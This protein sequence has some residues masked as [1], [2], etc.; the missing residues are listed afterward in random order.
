[1]YSG[2]AWALHERGSF[3]ITRSV[4]QLFGRAMQR[5]C[6]F[7]MVFTNNGANE[8]IVLVTLS[9]FLVSAT[10]KVCLCF[11]FLPNLKIEAI[12]SM[13]S[14]SLLLALWWNGAYLKTGILE[15]CKPHKCFFFPY[16]LF[17]LVASFTCKLTINVM[18]FMS[19]INCFNY[20]GF[21]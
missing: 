17:L 5:G 3:S 13:S 14:S 7:E 11:T 4:L 12:F 18:K 20:V 1:M 9:W 2:T 8:I 16:K 15:L 10:V 21:M 6:L 19:Y